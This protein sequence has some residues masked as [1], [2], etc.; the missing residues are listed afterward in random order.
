M[1][2][3]EVEKQNTDQGN[4]KL[5]FTLDDTKIYIGVVTKDTQY[6]GTIELKNTTDAKAIAN[7][8][9]AIIEGGY[10]NYDVTL[11][12][13][14]LVLT[15]RYNSDTDDKIKTL[16]IKIPVVP[17][18][19]NK[20]QQDTQQPADKQSVQK[21]DESAK[22]IISLQQ[23]LNRLESEFILHKVKTVEALTKLGKELDEL[24]RKHQ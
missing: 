13:Q 22:V 24:R 10:K 9:K 2:N 11:T 16:N 19:Q 4:A 23:K 7:L 1:N 3:Q 12:S 21:E 8:L 20:L 18:D 17:T 6:E 5:S 14:D 15:I